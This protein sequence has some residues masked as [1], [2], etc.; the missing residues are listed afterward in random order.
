MR[1]FCDLLKWTR[2]KMESIRFIE[3]NRQ[4]SLASLDCSRICACPVFCFSFSKISH[5]QSR[6]PFVHV[7]LTEEM[8]LKKRSM[9]FHFLLEN[10][11]IFSD[12][13]TV[14]SKIFPLQRLEKP[15]AI[16]FRAR[17]FIFIQKTRAKKIVNH[18]GGQEEKRHILFG[19]ALA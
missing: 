13:I 4:I 7:P 6:L 9:N 1:V 5:H 10:R 8:A 19:L 18:T 14:L 17:T 2:G 12:F 3:E 16:Y 11:T 15:R